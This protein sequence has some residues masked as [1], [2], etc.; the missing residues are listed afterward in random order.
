MEKKN[1]RL[2]ASN[3]Y[4]SQF[5]HLAVRRGL[6]AEGL[7][8]QAD[9][10][11]EIIDSPAQR[12]HR[13]KL[14]T[15]VEGVLDMLQDESMSL[16][17]SPIPR[18]SFYMMGRLTIHEPNLHKALNLSMRFY[19]MVTDAFKM[20]LDI[21]GSNATLK[22]HMKN[23]EMDV[24]HLLTGIILMGWHRYSSWLIAENI[25]LNKVYFNYPVPDHV[26]EYTYLFPGRHVFDAP[27]LGVS[28]HKKF[29]SHENVQTPES[30]KIFMKNCP[31]ELFLQPKT[32]FSLSGEL[33]LLLTKRFKEGFPTIEEAAEILYT[34]KRT[35]IRKLKQEGNSYQQ[36]KDRV[37]RDKAVYFLTRS[38]LSIK[39]VAEKIGFSDPAVFS[40]AF[41]AWT[42]H[43]PREYRISFSQLETGN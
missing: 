7:L 18:G 36:I 32:D 5:Y 13:D 19:R 34:T 27:F 26:A 41:K 14:A 21:E 33:Q 30:M 31:V 40:R 24:E 20:S 12:I 35:L 3:H 8:K 15:V 37:R 4:L 39:E 9:I 22:F 2:T 42:G 43:S 16:S 6:D 25:V 38:S 11:R 10:S 29:L 1:E 17:S 28:F 23:P